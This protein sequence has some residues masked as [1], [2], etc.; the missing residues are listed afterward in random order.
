MTTV[1][2]DP[3]VH[4]AADYALEIS[5]RPLPKQ[6]AP[7]PAVVVPEVFDVLHQISG[8]YDACRVKANTLRCQGPHAD[9][10]AERDR[11]E[12]LVVMLHQLHQLRAQRDAILDAYDL[13]SSAVVMRRTE[14]QV[15]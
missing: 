3:L 11:R 13:P 12:R 7:Q 1:W 10:V 14:Q 4:D 2:A 9:P 15:A 6:H 5:L 8:R